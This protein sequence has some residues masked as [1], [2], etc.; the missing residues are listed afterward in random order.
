MDQG[1]PNGFKG[2]PRHMPVKHRV[3]GSTRSQRRAAVKSKFV[4][5]TEDTS[6][7]A[8]CRGRHPA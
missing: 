4:S 5:T 6:L 8:Y 7:D 1:F 2:G 3:T